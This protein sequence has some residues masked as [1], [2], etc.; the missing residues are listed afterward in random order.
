MGDVRTKYTL[1]ECKTTG[2]PAKP[3]ASIGLKLEVMEKIADE[4]WSVGLEP[5]LALRFYAPDSVLA[6]TQTGYV[7]LMVRLMANG[8]E[9]TQDE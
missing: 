7:N 9:R 6:D 4:A 1:I 5:A 2:T 3:A 8:R